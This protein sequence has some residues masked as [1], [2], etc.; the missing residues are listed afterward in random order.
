MK[1]LEIFEK[2]VGKSA[3]ARLGCLEERRDIKSSVGPFRFFPEYR[4]VYPEI[5]VK[6][7]EDL[8]YEYNQAFFLLV[9]EN[10]EWDSDYRFCKD[11]SGMPINFAIQIDMVGLPES[12]CQ[13]AVNMPREVV[14]EI[15][16]KR[17]FEIENSLAMYQLLE[18]SF[19][20]GN[21]SF[22]KNNFRES[23]DELRKKFGRKI[24]LLAVTK[25][26]YITMKSL[27]FG[28]EENEDMSD[29]EVF[30]LSGFDKF[31]SPSDFREYLG[32]NNGYCDYLLYARTSDPVVKL[33][34][35]DF[36]IEHP[37]LSDAE[38]R[39]LIKENSITFNIDAPGMNPQ[40][41][42]ND[43]KHYMVPMNMGFAINVEAD[44]LSSSFAKHLAKKKQYLDFS[45]GCRL[46]DRFCKYLLNKGVDLNEV[47]SGNIH[48]RAKP[49][50]GTY[51]CYGHL[52]G[53][54]KEGRFRRE[55]RRNLLQREG[56]YIIQ[57]EMNVPKI[58][59]S[60]GIEYTFIDRNYLAFTNGHPKFL[61][62]LRSLMPTDSLEAKNGRNH[63]N[64]QTV[65][66]EIVA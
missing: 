22:F 1:E 16:R 46:S 11:K 60:D 20:N 35:P 19:S 17:I 64:T 4:I 52:V 44:L 30:E 53:A 2:H 65:M 61:G 24:A 63:G 39:R 27:E 59:N 45:D 7:L 55:L 57:L 18:K 3:S 6:A 32:H 51:G 50:K 31:F 41:R 42:I 54:L 37:L 62:G 25:Q 26:K 43:T 47:A 5:I 15:L 36:E 8:Y 28:K 9:E 10:R 34:K 23:L 49:L 33:K 48:L 29:E 12:F 58:T 66:G 13:E 14:R 40:K 56:G 38:M 21:N